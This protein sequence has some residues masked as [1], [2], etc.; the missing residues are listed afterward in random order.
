MSSNKSTPGASRRDFLK[1]SAVAGAAAVAAQLSLASNA[2]AAGDDLIKVG[3]IG[4]GG[5]GSGAADNVLH[6]AKGVKIVALG[7]AFG[8]RLN[9]CRKRLESLA[10]DD[11]KVQELGNSVDVDGRCFVGL[12][13]Y[14]Q[15]LKTDANY[16]ILATPPGFRPIHLQAAVA[17]GKNIFT[18]KPVGVDTAGIHKVFDAYEESKKKNLAIVA[19]TQ[20]RHQQGYL[21]T[22]KQIHDGAIGEI[23][24]GHCHWNQGILWAHARQ[25]DWSDL[26]YQMRNW[27]NF[28]WLCGD[29]IV[30]QHVHNIDVMN[31][32]MGSHPVK[33]LGMGFRTRTDPK[34]GHIYD[35][36][37]TGYEYPNGVTVLSTCRQISGCKNDI[38]ETVRGTKGTCQIDRH[39][40]DGKPVA[41]RGR[42]AGGD[43][44]V[45]EHT[46]LIESIRK[47]QPLNELRQ[48]A[49]STLTAIMGRM[50]AY[51][52]QEVT[53]D[54]AVNKSEEDLMPKEKLSFEM[55][56]PEPP[57]AV[58][59]KTR[60]V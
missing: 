9:G 31:W 11:E 2:R 15:V 27:Y 20:R 48:V 16:I 1:T 49:E 56:L 51:T 43:P 28:V 14:E 3:L 29:H 36:F 13:A 21:E 12:D 40:I 60:L 50:S 17:A 22:M 34:Y 39:T 42:R 5:R 59:G 19:G 38:S 37:S 26:V 32:A 18:E 46:D 55:S 53:W 41:A 57:V 35:F 58:P 25:P 4:C 6:S 30:E 24:G 45:R 54:F 44:Y 52:G 10:K 23:L 7:D 33:A 8:D 47:G